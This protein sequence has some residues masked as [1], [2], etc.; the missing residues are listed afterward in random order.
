MFAFG[1]VGMGPLL[2][3]IYGIPYLTLK[4]QGQ[5]QDKNGP[6]SNQVIYRSGPSILL[7]W[8]KSK[9]SFRSYCATKT[10][11]PVAVAAY[12]PVQK[13]KVTP[14]IPGWLKKR[15]L[16]FWYKIWRNAGCISKSN[17]FRKCRKNKGCYNQFTV[18]TGA[19]DCSLFRTN[20][21][22]ILNILLSFAKLYLEMLFAR[23]NSGLNMLMWW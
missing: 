21:S 15:F 22:E 9:K 14:S 10:L 2:A 19:G 8:K 6:K 23:Y 18:I 1:F 7:K 16:A 11:R 17:K 4:I 3:E 5:G 20:F 12:K 13:H